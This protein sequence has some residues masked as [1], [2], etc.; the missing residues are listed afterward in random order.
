MCGTPRHSQR[1]AAV[2]AWNVAGR[3]VTRKLVPILRRLSCWAKSFCARCA[4]G[5]G[6]GRFHPFA[7]GGEEAFARR[8]PLSARVERTQS[9]RVSHGGI[10]RHLSRRDWGGYHKH[11]RA[12][13]EAAGAV[14][15]REV[16]EFRSYT[17][18]K[19]LERLACLP[20]YPKN[21]TIF[22]R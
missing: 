10:A 1:G 21:T 3:A 13:D 15:E 2:H 16:I 11:P 17:R 12:I 5:R 22:S 6:D 4:D 9:S 14:T 20:K 8:T 7:N 19:T 18:R